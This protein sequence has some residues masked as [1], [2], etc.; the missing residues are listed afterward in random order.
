M[1]KGFMLFKRLLKS[2]TNFVSIMSL[3][4]PVLFWGLSFISTKIV[5][6]EMPPVTIAF[7]RQLIAIIPLLLIIIAMR[8]SLR[9][10]PL[11]LLLL[12]GSS[13]FGIVLY[14]LFE[15]NGLK[16]TTAASA[17]MIVAAVP[18]F[19]FISDSLLFKA[20][21]GIRAFLCI[22]FSIA[23]V[24]LVVSVNG[25]LDFSS[26]TFNGNM[27]IVGAMLS[28]VIYTIMSRR[29]MSAY[30]TL[31]ITLYQT[32]LSS[33]ILI[34]F[35]LPETRFWR[36]ISLYALLNLIYLGVLCSAVSYFTFLYAIKQFGATIS[37]AF[38]NLIPVVTVI[39]G[40]FILSE[41]L[42]PIQYIGMFLILASLYMLNRKR[43]ASPI[44]NDDSGGVPADHN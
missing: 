31:S 40:Y 1:K 37:S 12:A 14:F 19:T 39:G 29:L 15:N 11:D 2:G 18:V 44:S 28:W 6:E 27:L 35:L 25:R 20:K 43:S 4:L 38:L 7:M 32:A 26:E 30:S 16:Y 17:S 36:P 33:I 24:Y 22:I 34:P 5:L 13:F 9:I 42:H 21:L 23:G 8:V 10:K 3:I 41:K